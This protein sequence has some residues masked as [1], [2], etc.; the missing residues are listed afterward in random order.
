[1][2]LIIPV[3]LLI[4]AFNVSAQSS[5]PE[6]VARKGVLGQATIFPNGA[7][8]SHTA[9]FSLMQGVN[10]IEITGLS[11][12]IDRGSIRIKAPDGIVI[13][14]Y[15][16]K[17]VFTSD[18][19]KDERGLKAISDSLDLVK[20][21][22]EQ[23]DVRAKVNGQMLS[24]LQNGVA[25]SSDGESPVSI[26]DLKETLSYYGQ[27][28]LVLEKEKLELSTHKKELTET[29][30]RLNER[31]ASESVKNNRRQGIITVNLTVPTARTVPFTVTYFTNQAGWYPHYDINIKD[32]D[33]P[34][35]LGLKSKVVQTT[36]LDW[37]NITITLST[38]TPSTGTVAPLFRAWF[39]EPRI[40]S[41]DFSIPIQGRMAAV[42]QNTVSY[43]RKSAE[44]E[45]AEMSAGPVSQPLYIINGVPASEE[46]YRALD[47]NLIQ[48]MEVL[49]GSAAGVYGSR[50]A[51]GV[52]VV[53]TK[54]GIEDLVLVEDNTTGIVY[55]IDIPYTIPGNGREQTID[56]ET[57]QAD[58]EYK[59]YCAPKLDPQTFLVAEIGDWDKLG[60]LSGKANVTFNGTYLGETYID[61]FSTAEKLTLTLGTDKRVVVDRRKM[62]DY[63]TRRTLGNDIQ[64]TFVYRISVRNNNTRPVFMVTK[65]QYPLSTR[66][67]IEAAFN[68]K[69]T[70]PWTYNNHEVGVVTWEESIAPGETKVYEISYTVKYPKSLTIN[71]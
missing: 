44:A 42:A 58:A 40:T 32:I 53:T 17:T 12:V 61:A 70:T 35:V 27:E 39:L 51:D 50:S 24:L 54:T 16:Y 36:G 23:L 47:P 6:T 48:N 7:E 41:S 62:A 9:T 67:E 29:V 15:D 14:S 19:K 68:A 21:Q 43:S 8:L 1:M 38:S 65:D 52:I 3:L 25:R 4:S 20:S 64:Q 13:S 60:L 28:A 63:S 31:Y 33:M 55:N 22:I 34:V 30:A 57:K 56:L 59:Y 10:R 11:P 18:D 46:E 5:T 49:K 37:E 69:E 71:L 2:K 45:Y 66:K 26:E